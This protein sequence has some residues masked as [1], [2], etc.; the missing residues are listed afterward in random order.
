MHPARIHGYNTID[1]QHVVCGW[2]KVWVLL[3]LP[4]CLASIAAWAET[5][6]YLE[7]PRAEALPLA[8]A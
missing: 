3:L 1:Q 7:L 5:L 4:R 8:A 2:G 6:S